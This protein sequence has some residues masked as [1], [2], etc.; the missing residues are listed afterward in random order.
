MINPD[1]MPPE[2]GIPA[3]IVLTIVALWP[4]ISRKKRRNVN[5]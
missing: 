5:R 4:V 1:Y 3:A 2:F